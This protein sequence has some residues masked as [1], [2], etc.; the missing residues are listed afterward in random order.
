M[1]SFR[2]HNKNTA[3]AIEPQARLADDGSAY[4]SADLQPEFDRSYNR[5]TFDFAHGLG[6][7][8][9]FALPN[10]VALASRLEPHGHNYCSTGKIAVTDG[11]STGVQTDPSTVTSL[12]EAVSRIESNDSLVM[13]RGAVDDPLMGPVL[14]GMRDRIIELAGAALK[15]DFIAARATILIA[16][17]NRITAYHADADVNFL[18]QVSG[19]KH[20]NV[21]DQT[22]RT[23]VTDNDRERFFNGEEHAIRFLPDRQHEAVSYD[24]RAGRGVHVPSLAPHWARNRDAVSVAV[25]FNFDLAS[26]GRLASVHKVNHRL[27]RLGFQPG[28]TDGHAWRNQIKHGGMQALLGARSL[29]RNLPLRQRGSATSN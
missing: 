20:F 29:I 14:S 8:P 12:A 17:P 5:R 15:D 6:D 19:D 28:P 26:I 13:L 16:S 3:T 27:R 23:L 22:D 9:L 11:W 2:I 18:M 25:S 21:F 4:L 1:T 7:H 24:L 10:L